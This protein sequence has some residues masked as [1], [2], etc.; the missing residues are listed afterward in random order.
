MKVYGYNIEILVNNLF[1]QFFPLPGCID[2]N[3]LIEAIDSNID[4]NLTEIYD[5]YTVVDKMIFVSYQPLKNSE[6]ISVDIF[7]NS[8]ENIPLTNLDSNEIISFGASEESYVNTLVEVLKNDDLVIIKKDTG[9]FSLKVNRILSILSNYGYKICYS[10]KK[11]I[12]KRVKKYDEYLSILKRKNQNYSFRDID[13]YIEPGISLD[14]MKI[15]Q[16]EIIDALVENALKANDGDNTYNDIFVTAPTGSGKSILFQIPAIYLAEKYGLLTLVISPLIG[17]MNDQVNNIE[18]L[19]K[20]AATINSDY[21]P[22]QKDNIKKKIQNGEISILYIS[23]ETLLSNNPITTLIGNERKIGL[24]VVDESHIV[25]TWGKSFR[26]DYWFLGDYISKMRTKDGLKFP[27]A[28]FSA[29]ITYGGDDD[30][31]ADI[32]DSLK[33]RTG[34]YEYIAPMRRDDISF[35]ITI[36]EKENDYQKEKDTKAL[37]SLNKLLSQN[38]KTVA[39]FP[40]VNQ[41]NNYIKYL[42]NGKVRRFSGGLLKKEK[43]ESLSEFKNDKCQMILATK[44]FGMGID[45]D[46]IE[47][48]YHYAPTGN[49]CDYVQ[50]I[51]RAARKTGMRGV[52]KVDFFKGYDFKYIN[53]LYGMSSIKNYQIIQT[54]AKIRTIYNEKKKRNFTVSPD[55]FAFI[56]NN[57]IDR[58]QVDVFFKTVLLMI[59]KDF[60]RM[61]NINFKPIVFKPR[62]LFTKAFVMVKTEHMDMFNKNKYRKYFNLYKTKEQMATSFITDKTYYN[63]Y[64]KP[65]E[66][67]INSSIATSVTYQGD[68][69]T[70]DLKTMWEENFNDISFAQFKY[71]FYNGS[72]HEFKI[73]A[74]L[75]PEYI[76]T[77]SS[78]VGRFEEMIIKYSTILSEIDIKFSQSGIGE[79]Q[80]SIEDIAAI[81]MKCESLDL[82][83]YEAIA[84]A[85][86]FVQVMNNYSAKLQ[87]NNKLVFKINSSTGKYAV[88]S[89]G[90]FKA[91]I[92]EMI[93]GCKKYYKGML[94]ADKRIF[95]IG[96]KTKIAQKDMRTLTAQLLE[97]LHLASYEVLS[98]ERPEYFIRINSITAIEKI[99]NNT[100]YE[101]EMVKLVKKRHEDSK[102]RMTT[103]FTKLNNDQERWD[104]IEKYFAGVPEEFE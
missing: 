99:L 1:G 6:G 45:I 52:A 14:T 101:S 27:I 76:L 38:S 62:S 92:K 60:E 47:T 90:L 103:F 36:Y 75:I 78:K 29:T 43:D 79:K 9:P 15:N 22:E 69:Y 86:N 17:L 39:Y 18:I 87:F 16:S 4:D 64:G 77:V 26:P 59:Q 5:D 51:G 80:F 96:D 81:F 31:H 97:A 24:L 2:E 93:N 71:E 33:M 100:N 49:L 34:M 70:A 91:R 50:E 88:N 21:T 83:Q 23:P 98:G 7:D 41:V 48:V 28:T 12:S 32:I 37:D 104:Y 10:E 44:A 72:L 55:E 85:T 68:V 63:Y 73:G 67:I 30:M 102:N 54:L 53:Q 89:I 58:D 20:R 25:T 42:S 11:V 46:N 66:K 84:L 74:D 56:F 65:G 57:S 13:F 61:P 19:S 95:L 94:Q 82:N 35:D 8:I 3:K 40:F